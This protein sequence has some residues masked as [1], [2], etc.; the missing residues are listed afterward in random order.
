MTMV[1]AFELSG[2]YFNP[3]LA[4]ALQY[5]CGEVTRGQHFIV[6]W[7]GAIG[8]SMLSVLLWNHRQVHNYLIYGPPKPKA[9]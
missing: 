4:T 3:V 9:E 5:N 7:V 8:G 2:G 6:Y 1:T